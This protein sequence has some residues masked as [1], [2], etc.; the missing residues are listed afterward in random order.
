MDLISPI[1]ALTR[2]PILPENIEAPIDQTASVKRFTFR[3]GSNDFAI[4]AQ[5]ACQVHS[6]GKI[7]TLPGTPR[8]L[9]GVTNIRGQ[10]LPVFDVQQFIGDADTESHNES[11]ILVFG[12]GSKS[13]AILISELPKQRSFS[14]KHYLTSLP[15]IPTGIQDLIQGAYT[16]NNNIWLD[17]DHLGLLQKLADQIGKNQ[18][19]AVA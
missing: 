2:E 12:K 14:N 4:Q 13:A 7:C 1:T 3:I 19:S 16:E 15:P 17:L 11:Y 9:S 18:P 5:Q 10:L 8:W 6:L